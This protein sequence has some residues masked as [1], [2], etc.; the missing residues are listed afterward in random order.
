[1]DKKERVAKELFP[2]QLSFLPCQP[3][4]L[5]PVLSTHICPFQPREPA[6]MFAV[7]DFE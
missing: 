5:S 4:I 3:A 6:V 7:E 1:M 2:P